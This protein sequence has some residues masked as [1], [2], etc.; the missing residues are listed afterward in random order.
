[1][2]MDEVEFFLTSPPVSNVRM[3]HYSL[4]VYNKSPS[5][6]KPFVPVLEWSCCLSH[7]P[8]KIQAT[9]SC[10]NKMLPVRMKSTGTEPT[11]HIQGTQ[12]CSRTGIPHLERLID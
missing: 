1:M 9:I 7:P 10:R 5:A 3:S 12:T 2:L 6:S 4:D 11:I 8:Q